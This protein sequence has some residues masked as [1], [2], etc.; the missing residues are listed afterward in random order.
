[1]ENGV[2]RLAWTKQLQGHAIQSHQ[3]ARFFPTEYQD[4]ST[5]TVTI[6][7]ASICHAL[8]FLLA[9]PNQSDSGNILLGNVNIFSRFHTTAAYF[10]WCLDSSYKSSVY[11]PGAFGFSVE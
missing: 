3:S 9:Y 4:I 8:D 6:Q 2:L 7:S 11:L 10:S 5:L 1:M